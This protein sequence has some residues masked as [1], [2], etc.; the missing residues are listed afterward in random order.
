[1][2]L[3]SKFNSKV[4]SNKDDLMSLTGVGLKTANLVL[5]EGFL[6]PAICVDTHVHRIANRLGWIKT[7]KPEQ[8]EQTLKKL[9]PEKYWSEL[10][11]LFVIWGQNQCVPISPFCSNCPISKFCHKSGITKSR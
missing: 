6:I 2:Q 7:T 5:S 11:K 3:M 1:M 8:T 10:N 4:P 9:V